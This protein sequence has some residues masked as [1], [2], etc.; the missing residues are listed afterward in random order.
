MAQ[1]PMKRASLS[2]DYS[3]KL[4]DERTTLSSYTY[5][6]EIDVV[7]KVKRNGLA[8]DTNHRVEIKTSDNTVLLTA[9]LMPADVLYPVNVGQKITIYADSSYASV[10]SVYPLIVGGVIAK[11]LRAMSHR[12][13]HEQPDGITTTEDKVQGCNDTIHNNGWRRVHFHR[14]QISERNEQFPVCDSLG[15]WECFRS[16]MFRCER[17]RKLYS[18][19]ARK[20]NYRCNNTVFLHGLTAIPER[21]CA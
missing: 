13:R 5:T 20:H 1:S 16:H 3:T 21:G 6:P 14:K 11:L 8:A 15:L 17:R 18:W 7:A 9:Y 2:I 10:M 12:W 4:V 19:R